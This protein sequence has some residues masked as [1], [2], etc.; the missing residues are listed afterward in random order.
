MFLMLMMMVLVFLLS[1]L[2]HT[3]HHLIQGIGSFDRLQHSLP[4][5]LIQRSGNNRRLCIM[6]P[7][8]VHAFLQLFTRHLIG[9]AQKNSSCIFD[10]IDKK[11]SKI[12]NIHFRL[13]GIH[14]GHRTVYLNIQI[15][16]HVFHRP[17]NI[18][19]LSHAGGLDQ[20]PFR[21]VGSDNLLQRCTEISHQRTADTSGIHFL[22]LDS[23]L[24]QKAS[25]YADL[26]E[27]IFYENRP[28]AIQSLLQKLFDQSGFPCSQK[29]GKYIYFCHCLSP[30]LFK[31][32]AILHSHILPFF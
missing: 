12:L 4:L 30:F 20:N 15:R 13:R 27:F 16:C 19:K 7:D 21:C 5:Q 9:S 25:V 23:R 24:L 26:A 28:A 11:F 29:T 10:L 3:A 22:D 32:S 14:H 2:Q 18:R 1:M 17:Q 6:L 31:D 8:Q